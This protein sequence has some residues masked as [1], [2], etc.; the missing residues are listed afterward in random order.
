MNL[1]T[2][3][4]TFYLGGQ[5]FGVDVLEVQ[6]ILRFQEMTRVPSPP[7]RSAASSTCGGRS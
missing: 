2:Q 6:E 5:H 1:P 4:C 3:Y 7:T